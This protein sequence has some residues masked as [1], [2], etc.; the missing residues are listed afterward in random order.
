[1]HGYYKNNYVV[2]III[3]SLVVAVPYIMFFYGD[4]NNII[5]SQST[6]RETTRYKRVD[7]MLNMGLKKTNIMENKRQTY[8][9]NGDNDDSE[10]LGLEQNDLMENIRKML[11][12][13]KKNMMINN[14]N[15]RDQR[16]NQ[17]DGVNTEI[18]QQK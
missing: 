14:D 7:R 15:N 18:L 17:S 8:V 5:N 6:S 4:N 13:W 12:R 10:R 3:L 16:L 1:M 11:D 9:N 2:F